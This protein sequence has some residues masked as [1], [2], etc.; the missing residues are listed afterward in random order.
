MA[1]RL[2]PLNA[3]RAFEAAARHGSFSAAAQELRV[4]D[5]AVSQQVRTLERYLGTRLFKRL[6]RGLLLTELG[7]T[8]LPVLTAGFD[9][10]SEA[11]TRLRSGGIG[12]LLT[13]ATLPAFATGWLLPR[14]SRF[15]DLYPRVDLLLKTSRALS[16]FRH[17][18]VDVAIRFSAGP[19]ND[20]KSVLLLNEDIFP[21]A[22]PTLIPPALIPMQVAD[23]RTLPLLHDVD[24]H[25]NQPWLGWQGWF[26]RAGVESS[27][28]LR[29]LKFTD[30]IVLLGAAVAGLGVALGRSPQIE[31]LLARGQL[32]RLTQDSWRAAWAYRLVAPAAN[33]SR[34]NV[35]AFIDW[36]VEE[37][38]GND[39]SR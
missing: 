12:G 8:Y 35:R 3:L 37:A 33:F 31:G 14:I 18:D 5:S 20:T 7:S 39:V 11:T 34:P 2:P 36:I 13:V 24:A 22:S 15:R 26:E 1:R 38:R 23:L 10:L 17:E 28:A 6:P 16:D 19:T 4:T 21:V 25:P 30:S 29:G 9:R 32:V 27:A